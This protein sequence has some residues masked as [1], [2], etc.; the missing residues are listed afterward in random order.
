MRK[1]FNPTTK[2]LKRSKNHT[3]SNPDILSSWRQIPLGDTI[4]EKWTEDLRNFPKEYPD[5]TSLT[6]F[7]NLK[8]IYRQQYYSLVK[9]YPSFKLA[10]EHTKYTLGERLWHNAVNRKYDWKA[11]HFRLH[12]YDDEFKAL[13][14]YHVDL[15]KEKNEEMA[16]S[17]ISGIMHSNKD[18][19]HESNK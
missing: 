7:M 19:I 1:N 15:A 5:A 8:E 14:R 16:K 18:N 12:D 4:V 13:D 11:V 3:A 17:L 10:H 2:K 9:K 6:Q